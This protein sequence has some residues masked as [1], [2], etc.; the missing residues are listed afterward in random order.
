MYYEFEAGGHLEL[1]APSACG[2][3]F[4]DGGGAD[5]STSTKRSSP[6]VQ[7]EVS[8][9]ASVLDADGAAFDSAPPA[10][11]PPPEV[12]VEVEVELCEPP[13]ESNLKERQLTRMRHAHDMSNE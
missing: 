5:V 8:T 1:R 11:A 13:P 6:C 4:F 2:F 12:E 7:K 9:I 3:L 10:P